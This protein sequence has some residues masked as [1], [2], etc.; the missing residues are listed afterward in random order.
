MPF[1]YKNTLLSVL[2]ILAINPIVFAQVFSSDNNTP[3]FN[4]PYSRIGLGDI[5]NQNFAISSA[6]GGLGAAFNSKYA[7]NIINPASVGFIDRTV[8]DVAGFFRY[9]LLDTGD[10]GDKVKTFAGNFQYFSLGFPMKNEVNIELDNRPPL[11][12]W[13]MNFALVPFSNVGYNVEINSSTETDD[14]VTN[15][16]GKGG[17]Y[18]MIW[19]NAVRY[20]DLSFG[21]NAGYVFGNVINEREVFIDGAENVYYNDLVDQI[22]YRG[23]VWSFGAQYK[24]QLKKMNEK[25]ELVNSGKTL[26]AGAY[27]GSKSSINTETSQLFR[28]RSSA[29]NPPQGIDTVRNVIDL[30]GGAFLPGNFGIG[31]LYEH[32]NKYRVGIDYS[33]SKWSGYEND[34]K[35]ET[36]LDSWRVAA[37][38]EWIPDVGSYNKYMDRVRYRLGFFYENDPRS[39]EFD[40]QL[41]AF[42][43]TL[44]T[45]MPIILPRGQTAFFNLGLELGK[46]GTSNSLDESY[47]KL[48]LGFTLNDNLWFYKRKFN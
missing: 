30:E 4:S 37:G 45:G 17:T 32:E 33:A 6:M 43:I 35:P 28:R 8:F 48:N 20:K 1:K 44:G 41:S 9:G 10:G 22:S 3:K 40:E 36:L 29:F 19:T 24:Y 13:R 39:D 16:T 21:V 23:V 14:I 26:T 7:V 5:A 38:G 42:G 47:I 2:L 11:L 25:K 18:K 12:Y 27:F 15:F 34:A 46:F 31:L